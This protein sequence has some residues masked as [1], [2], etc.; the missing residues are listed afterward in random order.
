MPTRNLTPADTF[1]TIRTWLNQ[2]LSGPI[3]P[4]PQSI[5]Q[6]PQ[7]K[8]L[9]FWFMKP[10]GYA[11]LRNFVEITPVEPCYEK[12][13]NGE[14]YHLVYLGTAGTGKEGNS[15]LRERL[16]WHITQT[17]TRSSVC[18]GTLSTLRA[19]IGSLLSDDLIRENTQGTINE[20][21]EKWFKVYWI[22]YTNRNVKKQ[23]DDDEYILINV[24]MPLF[25][26]K[27]NPNALT[28]ARLNPT[29]SYRERRNRIYKDSRN[30][31]GCTS[32]A[33]E[34]QKKVNR[35]TKEALSYRHQV[36]GAN[37]NCMEFTVASRQSIATV[38]RGISGLPEGECH[39]LIMDSSDRSRLVYTNSR[40]NGWR[41]TGGNAQNIYTCFANTDESY[42]KAHG[43]KSATPRW[44][45]IQNEMSNNDPIINEVIVRVCRNGA[46]S[47]TGKQ[48]VNIPIIS[49]TEVPP[50]IA[51]NKA[52]V[53]K[54]VKTCE[55]YLVPCSSSKIKPSKLNKVGKRSSL[56][57]LEFND[58]IMKKR[59]EILGI[60]NEATKHTGKRGKKV[61]E[62]P[63]GQNI[64]FEKATF[65]KDVYSP[66]RLFSVASSSEWNSKQ[67]SKVY[68]VSALFGIIRAD[69]LI[70]IYNLA[71]G[72]KLNL[73]KHI[74]SPGKFWRGE[75]DD[76][77]EELINTG[78]IIYNLL[79]NEYEKV[80]STG[81]VSKMKKPPIRYTKSE[82]SS[83]PLKRGEWLKKQLEK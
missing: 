29:K 46:K 26:I 59:K 52:E 60:L 5:P 9:Y 73:K 62:I 11:A 39:Y 20:I 71:M 8:G 14:K 43:Y 77:I 23:I 6:I 57:K 13:I 65:A 45:I 67:A 22:S 33:R 74:I 19:G 35:P 81:V 38:V 1:I 2:N 66:G 79:S 27:N 47:Y 41:K 18:S 16:E 15:N 12:E 56:S 3:V 51:N 55:I 78:C 64:N 10:A 37:K 80:F 54:E 30:K 68:I 50:K 7:E 76:V 70:P 63:V 28:N 36:V 31:L 44:E 69:Q 34:K 58:L 49:P 53:T 72:D 32:E 82:R 61:I 83:R 4:V 17:H 48:T 21:F 24:I 40:N 42:A 25:N 75:L